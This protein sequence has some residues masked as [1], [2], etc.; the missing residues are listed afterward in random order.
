MGTRS[1]AYDFIKLNLESITVANGYDVGVTVGEGISPEHG[2]HE[3]DFPLVLLEYM[4][5][6]STDIVDQGNLVYM[7]FIVRLA[8]KNQNQKQLLDAIDNVERALMTMQVVPSESSAMSGGILMVRIEEVQKEP[9]MENNQAL[10][11]A[12]MAV[13]VTI[14]SNFQELSS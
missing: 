14:T 4:G 2:Y 6:K 11:M 13:V 1:V 12:S 5:E 3:D 9:I 10:L 7:S 8:V